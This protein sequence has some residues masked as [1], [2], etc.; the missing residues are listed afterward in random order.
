[1][2]T[3]LCTQ[4]RVGDSRY[5][6]TTVLIM[7]PRQDYEDRFGIPLVRYWARREDT[8]KRAASSSA[9]MQALSWSSSS[10]ESREHDNH[11]PVPAT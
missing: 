10:I 8:G 4:M 3:L 5:R 7:G 2:S 6:C 1:M 9:A 11:R